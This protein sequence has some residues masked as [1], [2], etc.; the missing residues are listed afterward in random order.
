M[1]QNL[2]NIVVIGGAG[3]IGS[4]IVKKF[5]NENRNVIIGDQNSEA[6]EELVREYK[7]KVVYHYINIADLNSINQFKLYIE[8]D[9]K[10]I[11]HL[12]DIVG[13][14]L[15]NEFKGLEGSDFETIN[16]TINFNL[17]SHINLTKILLPLIE[18]DKNNNKSIVLLSSINALQDY[19]LPAYSSAQAGKIGFVHATTDELGQ[20]GI[21]IN[22]V[23]KGT[24]PTPRTLKQPKDWDTLK[25]GTA[26]NRLTTP[27]EIANVVYAFTHLM[28]PV[29]GQY[30]AADNNT[31][32]IYQKNK[33]RAVKMNQK[34]LQND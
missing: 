30:L 19:G 31:H 22:A 29:T 26:L 21:R 25:E 8:K 9:Y 4:A 2:E 27:E 23:L 6:G 12:I 20:K 16:N 11:T 1:N 34:Y 33:V 28:T 7:E 32:K 13:G 17:K 15:D 18:K 5:I 24:V 14:A 3:G 10:S